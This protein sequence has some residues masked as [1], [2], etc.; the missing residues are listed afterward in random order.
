VKMTKEDLLKIREIASESGVEMT[1]MQILELIKKA[2]PNIEIK[3]EPGLVTWLRQ[4]GDNS[5]S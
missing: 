3:D 4:H 2:R 5:T 1:P